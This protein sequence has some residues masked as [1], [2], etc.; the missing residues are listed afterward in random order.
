M[1]K[2]L[3]PSI[4]N[5]EIA[6]PNVNTSGELATIL[7]EVKAFE[8]DAD[9]AQALNEL[10]EATGTDEVGLGI[11]SVLLAVAEARRSGQ[12]APAAFADIVRQQIIAL[13]E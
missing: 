1:L 2:N 5:R 8:N 12:Q 13:R 11:K 10:Q 6:V 9:L 7:R 3:G 4:F